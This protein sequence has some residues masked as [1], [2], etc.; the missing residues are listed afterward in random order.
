MPPRRADVEP[1]GGDPFAGLPHALALAVFGLLTVEQRLRC[2]EVCRGWRA[3][4]ADH[5]AWLCLDLTPADGG[6]CSEAL[7]LA[8]TARA[9]GR[10]RT[11]RITCWPRFMQRSL[12]AVAAG[13]AAT[14]QELRILVQAGRF[15]LG[16]WR[17]QELEALA[18][19]APQLRTLEADVFCDGFAEAHRVLCNEPPFA[20]LRVRRFCCVVANGA[21]G[22]VL[23]MA[24]EMAEHAALASFLVHRAALDAPA[25]LD[26]VVDAALARRVHSVDL[27]QCS[28]SPASAPALA[29]LLGGNALTELCI[30][31]NSRQLL[32]GPATALVTNAL[33]ANAT[34]TNLKLSGIELW[35]DAASAAAIMGVVTAHPRLQLLD[36]SF[37]RLALGGDG[38]EAAAVGVALGALLL[39]NA[40]ALQTLSIGYCHLGDVGLHPVVE[41]LRHN[42]HLT[43][44]TCRGNR[45]SEAFARNTLLPAVRANTSLRVLAA[46]SGDDDLVAARE[47]EALV[48]ARVV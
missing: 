39:A 41:A 6:E 24:A 18:R 15:Y 16:H 22:D 20:P 33:R 44:L 9:C 36:L 25:A 3:T 26:A 10:L 42:T 30:S 17:V 47:A 1:A 19:A 23:A 35:R 34:L 31:D 43:N 48:A 27:G 29:R 21:A 2:I 4:L 8:A 13:N 46:S 28:L 7:L 38:L 40:P 5:A 32:D 45:M 12:R 11:L 14:L 37:N